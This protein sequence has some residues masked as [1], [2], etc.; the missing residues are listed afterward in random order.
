M[1]PYAGTLSAF[2]AGTRFRTRYLHLLSPEGSHYKIDLWA[3]STQRVVDTARYFVTGLFGLDWA[4]EK[5]ALHLIPNSPERGTNT[6]TPQNTCLR[7][8]WDTELGRD[9]GRSQLTSFTATYLPV[10]RARFREQNPSIEFTDREVY[11]M[12]EICGFETLAR[13][14]SPWCK[15]FSHEDWRNFEYARD[16]GHYY[17]AGPGNRY[18]ATMGWLWL[19]ATASLL[20]QGPEA[21]KMFFSLYATPFSESLD[22]KLI[23]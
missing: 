8:R 14:T 17:R 23:R 22:S 12:Q 3:S 20:R 2:R 21:G 15:A 4:D 5:A 13:G 7:Y 6:L 16:V 19:N 11:I 10:I 18:G 9:Y 1:G